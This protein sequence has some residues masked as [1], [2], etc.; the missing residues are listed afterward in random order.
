MHY[1][2][3]HLDR[4]I[5]A[6]LKP[7]RARQREREREERKRHFFCLRKVSFSPWFIS[8]P[9]HNGKRKERDRGKVNCGD[10]D[11]ASRE[12]EKPLKVWRT[13]ERRDISKSSPGP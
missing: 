7:Q 11:C 10:P 2:S 3:P 13:K 9:L 5:L 8:P 4:K 12:R 1:I 6:P